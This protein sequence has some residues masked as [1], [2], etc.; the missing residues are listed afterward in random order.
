MQF[1]GCP[2]LPIDGGQQIESFTTRLSILIRLLRFV[3]I[4][5]VVTGDA[6][7]AAV[8][9]FTKRRGRSSICW[10]ISS[11]RSTSREHIPWQD[12][13]QLDQLQLVCHLTG[14]PSAAPLQSLLGWKQE[15][16]CRKGMSNYIIINS[17]DNRILWP[18]LSFVTVSGK[19]GRDDFNRF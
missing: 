3:M 1:A 12:T 15:R 18:R 14:I 7:A 9:P 2:L 11:L 4:G 17:S 8:D 19:R 5:W 10:I 6:A 16:I 13:C